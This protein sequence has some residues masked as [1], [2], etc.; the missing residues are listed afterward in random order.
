VYV[1]H[2]ASST[3]GKEITAQ[4]NMTLSPADSE[5]IIDKL[6]VSAFFEY[7]QDEIVGEKEWEDTNETRCTYFIAEEKVLPHS[8]YD[9]VDGNGK[10]KGY[11]TRDN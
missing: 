7:N 11:S 10:A 2:H 3:A 9:I 5:V 6:D 8:S 4:P 1:G